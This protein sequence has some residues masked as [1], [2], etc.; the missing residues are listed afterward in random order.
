MAVGW[1][2]YRSAD[3]ARRNSSAGL[4]PFSGARRLTASLPVVSVPVL[5]NTK[6][7]I[8]AAS[9]MSPTFLIRMPRRAAADSAATM[10]D[11]EARMNAQGQPMTR[12]VM[13]RSRSLVK[14]QTI[15]PSTSTSGV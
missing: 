12:T 1:L 8:R 11:G 7:L 15:A 2:L 14:A 13:T 9:S 6:A 10:A 3:A 5:S 4:V